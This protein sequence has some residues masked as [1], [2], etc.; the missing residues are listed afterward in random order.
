MLYIYKKQNFLNITINSD[1]SHELCHSPIHLATQTEVW[2]IRNKKPERIRIYPLPVD[3]RVGF[4][5]HGTPLRPQMTGLR[6]GTFCHKGGR[7][8]DF[9]YRSIGTA[10]DISSLSVL[11]SLVMPDMDYDCVVKGLFG[12]VHGVDTVGL[13]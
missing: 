9:A 13:I 2:R 1:F 5:E 8:K 3:F 10:R 7:R 12:D 6:G 4:G 11:W